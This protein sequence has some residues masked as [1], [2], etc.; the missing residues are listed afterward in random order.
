[1]KYRS[2]TSRTNQRISKAALKRP[3]KVGT[4]GVFFSAD[5]IESGSKRYSSDENFE[6]ALDVL[7]MGSMSHRLQ[8]ERVLF[9]K[10]GMF[11]NQIH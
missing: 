6:M 11:K 4:Q 2:K 1:M 8:Q 10:T 3:E 9:Y 7:D 5:W